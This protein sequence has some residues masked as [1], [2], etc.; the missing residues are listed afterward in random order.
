MKAF[1]TESENS[2]IKRTLRSETFGIN[3]RSVHLSH[4]LSLLQIQQDLHEP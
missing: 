4:Y 3:V 1:V 2:L